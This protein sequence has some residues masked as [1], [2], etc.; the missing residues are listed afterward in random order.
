[1]FIMHY[2]ADNTCHSYDPRYTPGVLRVFVTRANRLLGATYHNTRDGRVRT[3]LNTLLRTP[4]GIK[5]IPA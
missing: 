5:R 2:K 1:M 4:A 3:I